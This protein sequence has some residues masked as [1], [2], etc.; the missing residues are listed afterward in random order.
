[1][2]LQLI[3]NTFV[4]DQRCCELSR[5]GARPGMVFA[6]NA[7]YS[8]AGQSVYYGI[9]DQG[10]VATGNVVLG[11]GNWTGSGYRSGMGLSDFVNVDLQT[12]A[13]D[14]EPV[15]GGALDNVGD[16]NLTLALDQA[17]RPRTRPV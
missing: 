12:F 13:V 11:P 1:Q 4:N 14:V 8:T 5:W 16:P 9:G 7:C 17:G 6:N 10:V 2:H 3:H 15:V